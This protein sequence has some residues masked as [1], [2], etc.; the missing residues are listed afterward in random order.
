M[1]E[2]LSS[3]VNRDN[4]LINKEIVKKFLRLPGQGR[5]IHFKNDSE[6][7][8]SKHG[9]EGLKRVEAFLAENGV[10][11]E[12]E[13]IR[14]LDFYPTGLRIISLLAAV[15]V[16]GWSEDDIRDLGRFAS[17]TSFVVRLYLRYFYSIYKTLEKVAAMWREYWTIGKISVKEHNEE[18]RFI[19]LLIED[20]DLHPLYCRCLEGYFEG[21]TK[22]VVKSQKVECREMK[23]VF[24]GSGRFR[25][26]EYLITY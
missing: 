14:N 23:C 9:E 1:A 19:I 4:D 2:P 12:Y 8:L 17:K 22:M 15:H 5:G 6:Y 7:I 10:K 24:S 13:K 16:F 11:I 3:A 26:H 20:L 18:K 21:I 25:G